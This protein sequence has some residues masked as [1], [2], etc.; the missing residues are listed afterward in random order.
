LEGCLFMIINIEKKPLLKA[1]YHFC[2]TSCLSSKSAFQHAS[3]KENNNQ[4]PSLLIIR[5]KE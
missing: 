4:N 5:N 2:L 3:A 1:R